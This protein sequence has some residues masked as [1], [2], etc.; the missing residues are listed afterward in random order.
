MMRGRLVL[1][2]DALSCGSQNDVI[3]C[4]DTEGTVELSFENW[5]F[6]SK[7]PDSEK[8]VFVGNGQGRVLD[9]D[10]VITHEV[11]HWFGLSH[12]QD[13]FSPNGPDKRT[14][15]M[16]PAY[17]LA[18]YCFTTGNMISLNNAADIRWPDRLGPKQ[19]AGLRAPTTSPSISS[20]G[21]RR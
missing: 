16:S 3:G 20:S 10:Q 6:Y 1:A 19:C 8:T 13:N 7:Y 4:A 5:R 17:S 2:S 9:L 21:T 12:R 11:G 18:G 15:S 14:N